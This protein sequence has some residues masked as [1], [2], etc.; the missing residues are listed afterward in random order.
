VLVLFSA[1]LMA[2]RPV[3]PPTS[4]QW[5]ELARAAERRARERYRAGVRTRPWDL[6]RGPLG[7]LR[8]WLL[9]L[10]ILR[11]WEG[12]RDSWFGA[13]ADAEEVRWL[14][15]LER[16]IGGGA[17]RGPVSEALRNAGRRLV[18]GTASL[19][20]PRP[21]ADV[22][23]L[24]SV[25]K[26]LVIRTDE[27]VGNQVLT[28]PLLRALKLGIPHAELH[29]LA[30][31]RKASVVAN[32]HVDRVVPFEKRLAFRRPWTLVALLRDLRHERYDVVV[33]A[34]HWSGASLTALL[35]ARLVRGRV[36]VGHD[37]QDSD[38]FLSH[39]VQHDPANEVEIPAKLELLR[40]L[41][42]LP[43]GLEPET[44]LGSDTGPARAVLASLG[45]AP[46]LALLNP[47]ARLADRRWPPT[48]YAA[49]A[50][51]LAARGLGVLVAW[52]PGEEPLARAIAQASGTRLAPPTDLALLAG[53][54]RLAR[55]CVSN[56]TGPMHLS[57]AVGTP[58]VGV[59]LSADATRWKHLLPIFEVAEP[60]SDEDAEA[61]LAACD[62]LLQRTAAA[63]DEPPPC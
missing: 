22:P 15:R 28:T 35:L 38:R 63:G 52:G 23:P 18:V 25:R 46:G 39:P 24:A 47:G 36:V 37:R 1:P 2:R 42:L 60:G 8:R 44:E 10:G 56:N 30:S 45:L 4:L 29:L 27:R 3:I 61:V 31:A 41:G 40:P 11:G 33:E 20:L 21:K 14:G 12:L 59:F 49:V 43:C 62:R 7:F 57:V 32:R 48:S 16:E 26:V 58:T 5:D 34:G 13:R 19:L 50:R 17:P 9:G 55:L 54:L 51:G 6:L 53:L